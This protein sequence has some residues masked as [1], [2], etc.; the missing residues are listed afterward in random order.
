MPTEDGQKTARASLIR[1][2]NLQDLSAG[3]VRKLVYDIGVT[4]VVDLRSSNEL[5]A[6]AP[7]RWTPWRACGTLTTR[8][9]PR[10]IH[11]RHHRRRAAGQGPDGQ[12][13][14][15]ERPGLR[16]LPGYLEDRP[17]SGG[18]ACAASRTL[19]SGVVAL[20]GGQGQTGVVC[21]GAQPRPAC[22]PRPWWPT[23]R[24]RPSA[25][26]RSSPGCAGRAC[27]PGTHNSPP[28]CTAAG[29]DDGGVPRADGRAVWRVASWLTSHGLSARPGRAAIQAPGRH[30]SG[31]GGRGAAPHCGP[32]RRRPSRRHPRARWLRARGAGRPGHPSSSGTGGAAGVS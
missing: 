5:A 25:P 21:A 17:D 22:R 20:R 11:Y 30:L 28:T 12:D 13:Q 29:R 6:E 32:R 8:C 14:V 15:P 10:W 7:R 16:A 26:R 31:K 27:T 4:T 23:T 3:D 1:A 19:G 24:P 9:C 2:D 18:R